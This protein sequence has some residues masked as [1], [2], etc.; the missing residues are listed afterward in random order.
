MTIAYRPALA[1]DHRFIVS[2]W[3]SSFRLSDAAGLIAMDDWAAV[4]HPQ[5]EKV[6]ARP[7]C[8]TIVAHNPNDPD[9]VADLYGFVALDKRA[10]VPYVF[11]VYVKHHHRGRGIARGLFAAAGVDPLRSFAFACRT[12]ASMEAEAA[13]KIPNA[14]WEPLPARFPDATRE[15]IIIE[16]RRHGR[17]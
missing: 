5:I 17:R 6:L 10:A 16:E 8:T 3:S 9:P 11:Y 1:R 7:G 2:G 14:R 13:D 4:M 12:R 15:P